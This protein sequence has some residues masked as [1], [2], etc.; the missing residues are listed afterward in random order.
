MGKKNFIEKYDPFKAQIERDDEK[1]SALNEKGEDSAAPAPPK[2]A[3]MPAKSAPA[4]AAAAKRPERLEPPARA[5]L[6][7]AD[8]EDVVA[9][10]SRRAP[11]DKADERPPAPRRAAA[12]PVRSAERAAD[13]E[14]PNTHGDF[15]RTEVSPRLK[16]TQA[17]FQDL[18]TALANFH[19]STGSQIHYSIAT[20]ALWGLL[21]QAEAQIQEELRKRPLGRLP[22][23]R[24]KLAY[25]EY[26]ERVKQAFAQAFRKLPRTLFQPIAQNEAGEG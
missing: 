7:E 8:D 2:A 3:P 17:A 11:Q 18:E 12:E 25:A 9:Q 13:R 26:E 1:L 5:Y 16:V 6:E 19:R 20:R 4:E 15:D 23:T 22:S 21:I 14:V 24:D 10:P